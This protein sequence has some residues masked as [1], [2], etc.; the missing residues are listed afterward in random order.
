MYGI[1]QYDNQTIQIHLV[2]FWIP[3]AHQLPE[4]IN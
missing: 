3:Q 1:T 2:S 4:H